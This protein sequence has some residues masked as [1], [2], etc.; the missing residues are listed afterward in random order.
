MRPLLV[1]LGMVVVAACAEAEHSPTLRRGAPTEQEATAASG[2]GTPAASPATGE[3]AGEEAPAAPAPDPITTGATENKNR[4]PSAGCG[5]AGA[6]TGLQARTL[7]VAGKE[8]R[9][10]RFVPPTY[11]PDAPLAVVLALHGA[12][13][14]AER[15]RET[16]G[17]E[18]KAA[19]KSIFIYPQALELDGEARWQAEKDSEDHAFVDM[20]LADV[21]KTHCVDRDRVFATGF[22]NGARMTAMLGCYRGDRLRAIAPVAPGGND[23]T[24]P[25]EGCS[26]EVALWAGLGTED[27]E[28]EA[29]AVRVR[30]H[31]RAA[32]GCGAQRALV[33]PDGCE[34]YAHAARQRHR[35]VTAG[36]RRPG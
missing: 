20:L 36:S 11:D 24:L 18:A 4:G 10:L 26:G 33:K 3:G 29:G 5:K 2:A 35:G 32:N 12:G 14:T 31:Y 6:G 22:S 28:H 21:D 23:K 27:A 19:G 25:L 16:F 13:G 30:D 34:A 1:A 8:R 9:Y 7:T 15:A 17:L